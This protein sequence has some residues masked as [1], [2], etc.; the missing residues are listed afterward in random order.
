MGF[1]MPTSAYQQWAW[2][3][4]KCTR[5]SGNSLNESIIYIEDLHVT[6]KTGQD[7]AS[8][9]SNLSWSAFSSRRMDITKR[10]SWRVLNGHVTHNGQDLCF[11]QVAA[12]FPRLD[13]DHVLPVDCG[14]AR[15]L[16]HCVTV[17]C[18]KYNANTA[19]FNF[20]ASEN[21]HLRHANALWYEM[22]QWASFYRFQ[23]KD[24]GGTSRKDFVSLAPLSVPQMRALGSS[25][26]TACIFQN[27]FGPA[28]WQGYSQ[29][30]G[31]PAIKLAGINQ[32]NQY[33]GQCNQSIICSG[34]CRRNTTAHY[35]IR[36]QSPLL[37]RWW[38]G[39]ECSSWGDHPR[40]RLSPVGM[41]RS[42]AAKMLVLTHPSH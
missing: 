20:Q 9:K 42:V 22:N 19:A 10:S 34:K 1:E 33:K 4:S 15:C 12:S 6:Q 2:K 38:Q 25:V 18:R 39:T 24:P 7:P 35:L 37:N 14:S 16:P 28:L 3:S 17:T 8:D 27:H 41:W 13:S 21:Y 26:L 40:S 30:F 36:L 32:Y 29:C 23:P 31:R 5:V 11:K